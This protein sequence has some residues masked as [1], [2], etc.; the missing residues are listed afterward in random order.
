MA[1]S[2]KND[3]PMN[4]QPKNEGE[5]NRSADRQ[6]REHVE[7]HVKSGAPARAAEEAERAV[8][9]P[10]AE[11]LRR[12]EDKARSGPQRQDSGSRSRG[13]DR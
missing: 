6:Y 4:D 2:P 9:G 7:T 13:D 10:E 12:A 1:A 5:G 8:E 11:E 3:Q